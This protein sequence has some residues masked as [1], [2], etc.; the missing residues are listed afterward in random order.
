MGSIECSWLCFKAVLYLTCRKQ[1]LLIGGD[2]F[3]ILFY[4][5]FCVHVVKIHGQKQPNWFRGCI[6]FSV[7]NREGVWVI[8]TAF[9]LGNFFSENSI[10]SFFVALNIKQHY[11]ELAVSCA[12]SCAMVA[13]WYGMKCIFISFC[14]AVGCCVGLDVRVLFSLA[15]LELCLY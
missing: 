6:F 4:N 10:Y 11:T 5:F 8:P 13:Q 14:K 15:V 3:Y 7:S 12:Q 9:S 1:L 2:C